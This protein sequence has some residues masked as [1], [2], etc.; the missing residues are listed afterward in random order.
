MIKIKKAGLLFTAAVLILLLSGCGSDYPVVD[1]E[2]DISS[3]LSALFAGTGYEPDIGEVK[4]T[5]SALGDRMSIDF[6]KS[7]NAISD[8]QTAIRNATL[9]DDGFKGVW[10]TELDISP[11]ICDCFK[12]EGL[13][14]SSYINNIYVPATLTFYDNNVYTLKFDSEQL[15]SSEEAI[16]S[17]GTKAAKGYLSSKTEGVAGMVVK[18]IDDKTLSGI[19]QYA[20][21]VAEQMIANGASGIYQ[22]SNSKISFD[23]EASCDYIL[24]ASELKLSGSGNSG[25]YSVFN[26]PVSFRK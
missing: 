24:T 10:Q 6:D 21:D 7:A 16:L 19:L 11:I 17:S 18:V 26:S 20:V 12:V 13:E 14:L 15:K 1:R 3:L 9:S 8:A 23:G 2:L 22:A 4:I 25:I 5:V